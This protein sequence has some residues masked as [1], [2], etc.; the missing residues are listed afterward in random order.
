MQKGYP[1]YPLCVLQGF[2]MLLF[3]QEKLGG[4]LERRE[5]RAYRVVMIALDLIFIE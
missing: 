4:S 5:G 2:M 3:F 1:T